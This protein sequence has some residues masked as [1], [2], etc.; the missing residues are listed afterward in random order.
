MALKLTHPPI[1]WELFA[2]SLKG[3]VGRHSSQSSVEDKNITPAYKTTL[4]LTLKLSY[5]CINKGHEEY[6]HHTPK[7]CLGVIFFL[8]VCWCYSINSSSYLP[9]PQQIQFHSYM[10]V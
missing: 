9:T 8:Q 2:F 1:Q 6:E 5:D 10:V 7:Y 4:R 3:K